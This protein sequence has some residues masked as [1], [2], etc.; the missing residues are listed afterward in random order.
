MNKITIFIL[1][2]FSSLL[3]WAQSGKLFNTDNQLSSSL[4]T[5]VY[6]DTNGFIWITTRNGLNVYDG[7][8]FRVFKK[9]DNDNHHLN[10]N[11]INCIAQDQNGN[12]L[13][14]TNRGFLIY[15]GAQFN[16]VKLPDKDGKAVTTYVTHI[17]LLKNGDVLVGTSGY[18][19]FIMKRGTRTCLPLKATAN[20]ITYINT[21]LEDKKGR[22]WI[23]T[24][25]KKLYCLN[26]KGFLSTHIA[27]T[28]GIKAH[29]IKEDQ[30]GKLYLAT[31]GQGVYQMTPGSSVFTKI[32]NIGDLP[33]NTIYISRD[34]RL[35]IGCDGEGISI[36]NPVQRITYSNPYFSN[37]INLSKSK[38]ESI[39]EDKQG[40]IWFSMFQKGVFMQTQ[41]LYD[42]GYMGFR[43]GNHNLIGDNCVTSVFVDKDKNLWVG[44]DKDGIYKLG[45]DGKN[46]LGHYMTQATILS[47]CQDL[48]GRIW[49][50]TY[51]Q[52]AGLLDAS[53][54][55]H[56]LNIQELNNVG[57][58]DLKCDKWG[59]VWIA[60]MGEGLIKVN[61]DGD[62]QIHKMK[63]NAEN[64]LAVNSIPNNYIA[65]IALSNDHSRVYVATSLGLACL[66][67]K[68]NSWTSAFNGK[69][70]LNKGSFS[71]CI[72]VDSKNRIW[73]GTED[74]A[75][76]YSTNDL[77]HPKHYTTTQGLSDN[78]VASITEDCKGR[79]W[80]GTTCGLSKLNVETGNITKFYTENGLQS[81]EFSDGAVFT[82]NNKRLIVMGGT[83]GINWFD[84][85][86]VKQHP[87]RAN[88]ILSG[89][90]LGN[91]PV[92]PFMKSGSYTITESGTYNTKEFELSHDDNNFTLQLST[93]T[94]NNI[95][96]ITYGYS[97]NGEAWR[98]V[99][100]G[101]NEISFSHMPAG[102]YHFKIKAICN[103]YETPI[104][105]FTIVIHPVWY[106]SWWMKCL[107]I[108]ALIALGALYMNHRKRKEEDRLLLQKHIHAEEMGEAKLRFF[109]N[110][111]HEVRTPLT[112]I[113]TPLLSLIKEDK[114]PRRQGIY[115]LMR[116][117]SERILHLINQMMDL[118]K[119]DKGQMVMR[120]CQ[121][122]MVSFVNDEYKLFEQ[123]A[124]AKQINFTFEHD[125]DKL[126]AWIDRN[127]FDKVLMNVLSN[128][129]K[130]TPTGGKVKM[131][132]THSPHHVR[133]SI[134]D[135]GKGIDKDKLETIFQRFYQN[136]TTPNDRNVGTGIGLDLTRSLVELHY[137]TIIARNNVGG[138]A[139]S[140]SPKDDE[141]TTGSEFLIT[142][143]LG[144]DHLK[145][146]EIV[147]SQPE[148]NEEIK[149]L[150]DAEIEESMN[151]GD[152]SQGENENLNDKTINAKS[153]I[154]LVEDDNAI[155]EYLEAQLSSNYKILTF[156]NGKEALP[157][158][159]K[160]KPDLVISD[161]MMPEMDGNTLCT[162]IKDN[163]NTNHIPVILLTA[164]SRE[165]D[166][167]TGLEMGADAYIVKPFNMD[168]LRRTILNTLSVRRTLR[169][170]FSGQES[171]EDK[172]QQ[173]ELQSP[174]EQLM[175]RIMDVINENMSDSDLSVDMIAKQVGISRVHLHRK[176]KE[177]TNQT[178]HSFIRNI[179][180]KQAALLLSDSKHNVADVMYACGF[181][182][183]ASFSTMFKN[184]YGCSPREY[185]NQAKQKNL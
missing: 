133:I 96:Q 100:S 138:Q 58:F 78:S 60:T 146:E 157:E 143:P 20:K 22:I 106:A 177:L 29:D 59:N 65:K 67:V 168:I 18:G 38:V 39:I 174:D 17:L 82:A 51:T 9:V 116:K 132:L 84:A 165:E 26:K 128:A 37:Q 130:F 129:F 153:T 162:K 182:N 87:W 107:Y 170:K 139:D 93:L 176:M 156:H 73:Y 7:Y 89:L 105:E 57:T 14:G 147:E 8:N 27:G 41:G 3:T 173:I 184:L 102:T 4:A 74:G 70:C 179:R 80:M 127:N 55:Y 101:I 114:D 154:A 13:L 155:L 43:L 117:N 172:V 83:G 185:M 31:K 71:H 88:V 77:K 103:N 169:Y 63:K 25:E 124:L 6:Q 53:G 36:Y 135:S 163:V 112:L 158:I 64:N 1:A 142:L 81:N 99:Q 98:K 75:Y 126:N 178:P 97:I 111:S 56:R 148:Y 34:N 181:Y 21:L 76:C 134:K 95:E 48:K 12:I 108:I 104:K 49:V 86:R 149:E 11:Y 2:I 115:D 32:A 123:Q 42:F 45:I 24:E 50:G 150:E 120:M 19:I 44:T 61:P 110:I 118:R 122:D 119:I 15:D 109:M 167:L 159:I 121:T 33:I 91:K 171:Q 140:Q 16:N 47:I 69:N 23:I 35:F 72:F 85:T 136:P 62:V 145:P 175:K 183:A 125:C 5:Q 94:Y 68:K 141:F 164:M 52:G 180:L 90:I 54:N 113:L 152:N 131:T 166:Q 92:T 40:N 79:I 160:R 66:D 144:K 30:N 28:E 161:I 46:I 151:N 10:T 137:G